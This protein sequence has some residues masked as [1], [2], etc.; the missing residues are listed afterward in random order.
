MEEQERTM[1][2]PVGV[3]ADRGPVAPTPSVAQHLRDSAN[4]ARQHKT[5]SMRLPDYDGLYVTFRALD[6]YRE[7]RAAIREVLKRRGV[8]PEDRE[9][10]IAIETLLLASTGSYAEIDGRRHD[11][12]LPLGV[13]LYDYIW[14]AEGEDEV[15]PSSDSQAVVLLFGS[16]TVQITAM[17]AELD[18]WFK[19]T[20]RLVDEELLGNS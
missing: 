13:E 12:G 20:G 19:D 9:V 17:A 14:P 3:I 4:R 16:N 5:R 8:R 11:I 18:M 15:R 10:E 2:P 6:D 1:V 7:V